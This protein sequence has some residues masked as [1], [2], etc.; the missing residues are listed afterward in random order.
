METCIKC[1]KEQHETYIHTG[2]GLSFDTV[3]G[4]KSSAEYGDHAVVY[5]SATDLYYIPA[6]NGDDLQITEFRVKEGDTVHKRTET[7]NYIIGSGHHTNSHLFDINGF[8]YQAPITFYTQRKKWD[9]APGF[10]DGFNSRFARVIGAECMTCHNGLPELAPGAENRYTVI[11]KGIDC[12]RCHGP[13][14][15]HVNQLSS[16]VLIDTANDID[17]SIVNPRHLPIEHQIDLCQR[18]HLQGVAVLNDG[19]TF[20]DFKP[21]MRIKEHWNIFLPEYTGGTG[22]FIMA[23]QSERLQQSACF[24]QSGELSCITCHNPHILSLIHI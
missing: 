18:C 16:G 7:V 21:G 3:S 24:I 15:A 20:F 6:W 10:E 13:G 2:M 11:P 23:S 8:L 14:E 5:D 22:K 1:H 4:E 12:E 9:M 17:Y 19:S